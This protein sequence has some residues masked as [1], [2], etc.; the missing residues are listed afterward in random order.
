VADD[1]ARLAAQ[2]AD[3]TIALRRD[4]HRHPELG[5]CEFRTTAIVKQRLGQLEPMPIVSGRDLYRG[6]E[7]LG[8]PDQRVQDEAQARALAA[9]TDEGDLETMRGGF[10]GLSAELQA[11]TAGPT[12]AIRADLDAL[13]LHESRDPGHFPTSQGFASSVP[14]VMHAC[15]HDAHTAVLVGVA[16]LLSDLRQQMAGRVRFL[17]QPAEEGTRGA[18]SFVRAGLLDD[19]DY[20][21]TF[22]FLT[23]VG[24]GAGE[25]SAGVSHMLATQKFRAEYTGRASQFASSP[26]K[27]RNALTVASAVTLLANSIPRAPGSRSMI[28][29]GRLEAGTAANIVPAEATL[30][31]E[32]RADTQAD[33]DALVSQFRQ[34]S[35]GVAGGFGVTGSIVQTGYSTDPTCDPELMGI[36]AK[37]A[38]PAKLAVREPV[39]LGAS[40]DAALMIDHVQRQGGHGTYVAIGGG[41]YCPHHSPEFDVD[42]STLAPTLELLA[43]TVVELSTRQERRN[44]P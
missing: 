42:E 1:I 35:E 28:N 36:V 19:V 8:L 13:P 11:A 25:V 33:V 18:D 38:R 41:P 30:I 40:D 9:G 29:I 7:R 34:L 20:V 6:V 4:L 39:P 24:L 5:W 26:H 3:D 23:N 32:I 22:H 14:G 21:L 15:A 43:R 37:A 31:G 16:R 2:L 27:G 12:T 10:T 17:F 44:G